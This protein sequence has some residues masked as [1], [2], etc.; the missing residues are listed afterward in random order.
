[1]TDPTGLRWAQR[2][3]AGGGTEYAWFKTTKE[4]EDALENGWSAV[5]FP[6]DRP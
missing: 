5:T 2:A 3:A 1:M 6:E 4:Y